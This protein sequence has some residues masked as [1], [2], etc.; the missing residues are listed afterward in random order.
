[1]KVRE[2]MYKIEREREKKKDIQKEK[3]ILK[4]RNANDLDSLS[5][6]YSQQAYIY[7]FTFYNTFIFIAQI[8]QGES[9]FIAFRQTDRQKDRLGERQ[10]DC[11]IDG[12][13]TD[14]QIDRQ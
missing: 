12:I 9:I 7:T 4:K 5:S 10:I 6:F 11:Q 1:M 8:K 2:R 3:N 13:Q 14:I